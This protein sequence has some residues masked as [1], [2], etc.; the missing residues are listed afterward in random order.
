MGMGFA[1]AMVYLKT[2]SFNAK[3]LEDGL[4]GLAEAL[5]GGAAREFVK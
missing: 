3:Y 2:K 5:R 1:H 4:V